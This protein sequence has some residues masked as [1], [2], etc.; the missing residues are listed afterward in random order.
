MLFLRRAALILATLTL[1][2]LTA[3]SPKMRMAQEVIA[4]QTAD[5]IE[6]GRYL[7]NHVALCVDCHS[8]RDEAQIGGPVIPGKDF[9]GGMVYS[10]ENAKVNGNGL[11]GTMQPANLSAHAEDGLGAWTDGEILRAL[12]EG[13]NKKGKA[14]FPIMPYQ[15]YRSL[16]EKDALAIVAYL[17]TLPPRPGK[18]IEHDLDF[19]MNLIVNTIP[20]PLEGDVAEPATDAVSQGAYLAAVA[21]CEDCHS[22]AKR[23]EKIAGEEWSGGTVWQV[24]NFPMVVSS[25]ITPDEETGI[26][27][28]TEIEF[29]NM[30]RNGQ[31]RDG[32]GF[33]SFMPWAFYQGMSDG[34]LKSIYAFL[35][36]LKPVRKNVMDELAKYSKAD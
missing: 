29:I 7:V 26:G 12:R 15:N 24:G 2:S 31:A 36:T 17:R 9:A 21:G 1:T 6:R 16:S 13:V 35:R 4:P 3:C 14:L 32:R 11:P 8:L 20:Q 33:N 25:N 27:K 10:P 19:P 18:A 28:V 22:P 30:I 23:G 34:D 5:Q